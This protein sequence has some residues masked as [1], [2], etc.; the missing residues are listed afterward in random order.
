[1]PE[2]K[3]KR[4]DLSG[5]RFGYLTA[6]KR[7]PNHVTSGGNSLVVW[8]C[9]CDCGAELDVLAGSLRTG[10]TKS[11]GYCDLI[12][13]KSKF[14]D[15][16]GQ[17]FGYLTVI[18]RAE[19]HVSAGGN[20]FVAWECRC[21]CGNIIVVTGSH[22]STDHNR[23]CGKCGKFDRT[24]DFTGQ[25]IGRLTV[26]E[27][28]DEWYTYPN[29]DRDFKW[30]CKCDCGNTVVVRGNNLR[31]RDFN[32][33]CGCWR[34]E[35][36][37]RDEDMLGR[38]FGSCEVISRAKRIHVG[39]LNGNSSVDAWLC[40]CDCGRNFVA[41]GPQLR[42]GNTVSCGC[43]SMS[44]W[45]LWM[46]QFLDSLGCLYTPQ[47]MYDDLIGLHGGHLTYDFCLHLSQGDVLIECQGIQHYRPVDY[48]GGEDAFITQ[49]DHDRRKLFYAMSKHIPLVAL[50]CSD[51]SMSFV[52]YLDLMHESLD[53]YLVEY[54]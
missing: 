51:G 45:E 39:G 36:S 22:L 42:F 13:H 8:R 18:R 17:R 37:V 47:K 10:N 2:E 1:M 24:V 40:K 26:V 20:S 44:K 31:R 7:A 30:I 48:F 6:I 28:S 33:S 3:R 23:S 21:D 38:R 15:L 52:E 5:M 43:N 35:E 27:K 54:L 12:S 32:Q 19:N 25:K 14:V 34:Y 9:R 49:V 11:C 29:G 46:S 16:T 4:G 50:D 41:R 53:Q